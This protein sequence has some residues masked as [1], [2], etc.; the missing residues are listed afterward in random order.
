[1]LPKHC[2][3]PGSQY[4]YMFF[5]VCKVFGEGRRTCSKSEKNKLAKLRDVIPIDVL[6]ENIFFI[7]MCYHI[8]VAPKKSLYHS[9]LIRLETVQSKNLILILKLIVEVMYLLLEMLKRQNEGPSFG[10]GN[11]EVRTI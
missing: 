3:M 5:L 6:G 8:F 9:S 11:I 4:N 2:S 1:M 7:Y 10:L